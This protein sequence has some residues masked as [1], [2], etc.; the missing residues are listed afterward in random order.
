VHG[1]IAAAGSVFGVAIAGTGDLAL[2]LAR[3]LA[4][5]V[6]VVGFALFA[7]QRSRQAAPGILIAILLW[8]AMTFVGDVLMARW[9]FLWP[10]HAYL[11]P[12]AV[13]ASD[14]ALNRLLLT[15]IGVNLVALA[16]RQLRDAERA[17]LG[18]KR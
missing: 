16:I 1:G 14:Y 6:L 4:P 12:D 3:W 2:A 18:G 15:L 8:F 9:P 5:L 17:L 7:S 13:A 11:D 10:L